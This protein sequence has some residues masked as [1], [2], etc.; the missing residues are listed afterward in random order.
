L[1][2]AKTFV[3]GSAIGSGAAGLEGPET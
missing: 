3:L 1:P 2:R